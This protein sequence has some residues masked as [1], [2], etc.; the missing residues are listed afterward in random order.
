MA[1]VL[2]HNS[3]EV[4][5][6]DATGAHVERTK[7]AAIVIEDGV[8]LEVGASRQLLGRYPDADKIDAGRRLVTPG[9]VDCHTHLL[10][11]GQRA[12]EMQRR[13][14]G[15][16][17]AAIA[18]AGGGIRAS[19]RATTEASDATLARTLADRLA[20]W[21]RGGC[22]TVE[23][24]SGYGLTPEAE[25]RLLRLIAAVAQHAPVRVVRTALLLHAFPSDW[26]GER[27]SYLAAMTDLLA[28]LQSQALADAV[29]VYCDS[30]AFSV[31][32]C[33]AF[34][35]RATALGLPVKLHAEQLSRSGGARLAADLQALSAEHLEHAT[36]DD[37][38]ALAAAGTVGVLLPA[39][40]LTLGQ[41]LPRA[42]LLRESRARVALA[43][44]CNPGT[45]PATSLVECAAL[46]ARLVGL[47]ADEALL[48]VTYNAALALARAETVG[49]LTPGAA[50]DLVVWECEALEELTYW[51]PAV[52]AAVVLVGGAAAGRGA[53]VK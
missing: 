15:E 33:R 36:A 14:A 2:I 17:Y 29:D 28:A 49:H 43:T 10:F 50:G 37:W 20:H 31:E 30:V 39:A 16:S 18:A 7:G 23:V 13:L 34:L 44:D 42:Q 48:A 6:P 25:L 12:G 19:V 26:P 9:L 22:T 53:S 41:S 24:K 38:R 46:A 47:S 8:V 35:T 32:E 52:P 5:T 11:A 1:R 21:R 51:M 4:A 3:S 45:S 40:A 27:G